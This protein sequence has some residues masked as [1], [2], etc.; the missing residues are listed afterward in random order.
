MSEL[1]MRLSFCT[2]KKEDIPQYYHLFS[3]QHFQADMLGSPLTLEVSLSQETEEKQFLNKTRY[4]YHIYVDLNGQLDAFVD[5]PHNSIQF[6]GAPTL[7]D[8]LLDG[9]FPR[10]HSHFLDDFYMDDIRPLIQGVFIAAVLAD[11]HTNLN[12]GLAE[13]SFDGVCYKKEFFITSP[14]LEG[15]T[16]YS[17]LFTERLPFDRV[18]RWIETYTSICH[19]SPSSPVAIAALTYV[20]NR[21]YHESL[22]YSIIGLESLYTPKNTHG[23]SYKLQKRIPTLFPG[24]SAK[25]IR[26]IYA[27]RSEFTHGGKRIG[28]YESFNELMEDEAY[29]VQPASLSIALLIETLRRLIA[30]DA[31]QLDFRE[32]ITFT[33]R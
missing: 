19:R 29:F 25:Q 10:F 7:Y 18:W 6:H 22:V 23:I 9:P 14:V 11:P 1:R 32:N 15:L 21:E 13:T 28:L 26:D 2:Y 4:L 3:G 27:A 8:L 30:H 24:V 5:P 31:H 16:P 20:L 33:F 12:G 17:S